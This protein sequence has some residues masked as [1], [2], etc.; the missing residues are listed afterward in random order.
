MKV[1]VD[2]G[3]LKWRK[4]DKIWWDLITRLKWTKVNERGYKFIKVDESEW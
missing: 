4:E 2:D 3:W 1:Y